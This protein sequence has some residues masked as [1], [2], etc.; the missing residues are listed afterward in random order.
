MSGQFDV[1]EHVPMPI[2]VFR[3]VGD[4]FIFEDVNAAARSLNPAFVS[5]RGRSV[6]HLYADQPQVIQDAR[7]AVREK[8]TVVREMAVRRYD[9]TEATQFVRLSYVYFDPDHLVIFVQDIATPPIAEAAL[10]ESEARYRSL[11]DSLPDAVLLR[12]GDG[13]VLACN[14]VAV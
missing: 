13:R 4:D 1:F 5:M 12:G 11:V 6:T 7:R 2:Y 9:R 8:T 3:V 10:R 14:D